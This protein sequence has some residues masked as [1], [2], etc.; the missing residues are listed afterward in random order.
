ME[1]PA[2]AVA[3]RR[4][5]LDDDLRD[6]SRAEAEQEGREARVER[7][8]ADPR[9]EDG[10]RS[11]DQP[12]QREARGGRAPAARAGATIA[13]PSVVLCSAKPTTRKA[14]SASAPT[15]YAA[16]IATPSPRLCRP[17]PTAMSSASVAP[18]APACRAPRG[19]GPSAT[20]SRP[21][22]RG[23]RRRRRRARASRRR[24][25]ASP[26]PRARRPRASR[27][28]PRKAS[29]PTVSAMIAA[30]PARRDAP[31]PRQPEHPE[32]DGDDAD[33]DPEQR[34]QPE[35][36]EVGGGRLDGDRDLVRDR[37]AARRQQRDL[38]GL[39][40]DPGLLDP[41]GLGL[42]PADRAPRRR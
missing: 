19:A 37:P 36:R 38:V 6:R 7:R 25:P 23:R 17:M 41:D 18:D 5:E 21:S 22:A 12:E 9:A 32:R 11:C 42:Q 10:R 24:R 26:R 4:G 13:S 1:R 16:P 27:R 14:P 28:S 3:Q 15:E 20:P 39:A 29:R 8:G 30:Q 2:L 35:E 31:H 40:L 33:V 34:H